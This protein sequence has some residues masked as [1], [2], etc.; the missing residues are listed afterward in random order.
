[1]DN[2]EVEV[3]KLGWLEWLR[4]KRPRRI[5]VRE[6]DFEAALQCLPLGAAVLAI[7]PNGNFIFYELPDG[8]PMIRFRASAAWLPNEPT[9][10]LNESPDRVACIIAEGQILVLEG[11]HRTR[12]M[13]RDK[14]MIET[15]LGGID[16]APGWLDFLHKPEEAILSA[17][18]V[19]RSG[20][21]TL[22]PAK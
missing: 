17:S 13:A 3:E 6:A 19:E 20:P 8:L 9:W 5:I 16:R 21:W 7:D 12:G 10:G 11:L 22:V 1:M 2:G 14:S 18:S 4:G 15:D